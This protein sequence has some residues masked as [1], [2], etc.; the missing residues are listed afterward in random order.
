MIRIDGTYFKDE[1]GRTLML[2][3]VNFAG[4][5]KVPVAPDGATHRLEGFYDH[6]N[7]SF[8]GRP[9][10]LEEAAE[11]LDRLR[12]WGFDTLRFLVT[13]EAIE[14]EGPGVYDEDYLDFVTEVVAKAGRRGFRVLID[15]HQDVWSRFCGGDGA[16]GWTLEAVGFDIFHLHSTGAAFLHQIHGDPL[17][18]MVWVTNGSKLAAATVVPVARVDTS[19]RSSSWPATIEIAPKIGM[20]SEPC[21][22]ERA[23]RSWSWLAKPFGSSSTVASIADAASMRHSNS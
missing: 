8:V 14:H 4:S 15:P 9:C 17:P 13:W 1:H 6:R 18:P 3:G 10:L 23:H 2:R 7:V 12:R 16:P 22:L 19:S 21:S 5:S 20:T 11:H